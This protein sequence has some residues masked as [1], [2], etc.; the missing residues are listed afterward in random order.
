MYVP[1]VLPDAA[2]SDTGS[3]D[4]LAL[5]LIQ[6]EC[7]NLR[8]GLEDT[9]GSIVTAEMVLLHDSEGGTAPGSPNPVVALTAQATVATQRRRVRP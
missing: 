4:S 9:A 7:E 2:V 8:Q 1:W 6:T 3:I 5:A